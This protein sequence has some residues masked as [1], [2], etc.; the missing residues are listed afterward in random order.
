M[1]QPERKGGREG[2]RNEETD[3]DRERGRERERTAHRHSVPLHIYKMKSR[4]EAKR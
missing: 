1:T 2:G 4:G 3:T